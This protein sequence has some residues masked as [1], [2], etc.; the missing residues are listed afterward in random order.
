M[1]DA[2]SDHSLHKILNIFQ[3]VLLDVGPQI[4][5]PY[6]LFFC[7]ITICERTTRYT[8]W[9]L[10]CWKYQTDKTLQE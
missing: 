6:F 5:M 2:E 1:Q 7:S 10:C 8:G 3:L 4:G 9:T